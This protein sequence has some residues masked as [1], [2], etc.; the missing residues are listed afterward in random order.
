MGT[1][2]TFAEKD[3]KKKQVTKHYGS[4]NNSPKLPIVLRISV[5]DANIVPSDDPRI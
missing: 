2:T 5:Q 4:K 1:A 3:I